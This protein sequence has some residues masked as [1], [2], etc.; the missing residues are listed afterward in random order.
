MGHYCEESIWT[1]ETCRLSY[2]NNWTLL[3]YVVFPAGV[4]VKCPEL[5]EENDEELPIW[6]D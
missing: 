1:G 6:R 5:T 4:K 3:E 2:E